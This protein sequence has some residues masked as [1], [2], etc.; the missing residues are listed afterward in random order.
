MAFNEATPTGTNEGGTRH[1][2]RGWALTSAW[3]CF[4]PPSHGQGSILDRHQEP[5]YEPGLAGHFITSRCKT[6]LELKTG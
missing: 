4:G 5:E 6:E 3:L 1:S 2:H